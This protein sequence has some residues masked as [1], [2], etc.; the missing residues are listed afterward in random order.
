MSRPTLA[1]AIRQLSCLAEVRGA[2]EA[3]DLHA[4]FRIL[5]PLSPSAL[6]TLVA[7]IDSGL[8]TA[9]T[10]IPAAAAQAIRDVQA[11]G[12]DTVLARARLQLPSLHRWLLDLGA[13]T[14]DQAAHLARDF[15]I[16]I[17]GDLQAALD[18]GRLAK[19]PVGTAERL[20]TAA[21]KIA[22][23][24]S[25]VPLGRALD[26]LEAL[27]QTIAAHC[28]AIEETVVA[29]D[30]RRYEP[31][32]AIP[33]LVARTTAPAEALNALA[34]APGI[35]QTVYRSGRRLLVDIQHVEVDVRLA[36]PDD[37]GTVLFTAT[38]SAEHVK[39]VASRRRRPDLCA[40]EVDVYSHAG[41]PWIPAEMRNGTGE[42]DAAAAGHLPHLV[43][44][45]DMRGDLHMHSNYSDG[46]DTI[47]T[48][49][50][51]A[52]ALGYEYLA[53]TDH[54]PS[55]AASRTVTRG[56]LSRQREEIDRVRERYPHM[57]IL[58][59]IEVDILA[60]G[61]LDFSD[62]V[63]EQLDIV[64]ASLHDRARH[65]GA[66][67]TRRCLTAIHHPLVNIISHPA[68][69]LVGRRAGYPLD[70]EALFSAAV[71]TGTALEIDGAP[72]HLDL[73]GEHARAA[74]SAG[75]TVTI[76]SDCHRARALDRQMCL[77]VG[78]ARRGWVEAKQVLNTRPIGEVQAF[79]AAKRR[80]A[81]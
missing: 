52:D 35:D 79:I 23:E 44:R 62:A 70:F 71:E 26:L 27:Q 45:S 64:I 20:A 74:V 67:L 50:A 2:H 43:E 37:L 55:A 72:S 8:A 59:G 11:L 80:R 18:E 54:S 19:L 34:A 7:G 5:D 68:N 73:D 38:G 28:P 47:E 9:S 51:A 48:M 78:T 4:A 53:I 40:R 1:E 16:V 25:P 41:L 65:D 12:A 17:L 75:V 31:L 49:V 69:Q 57:T 42:V 81:R 6:A 15:G 10:Q 29:G 60:D 14:H 76:D 33:A 46:Q 58:H 56:Q 36:A 61:R 77:G 21:V 32:V 30:A 22:A 66:A 24:S 3:A 63:L 13:I 39:T